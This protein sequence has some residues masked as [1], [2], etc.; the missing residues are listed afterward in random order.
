MTGLLNGAYG[1]LGII[2][3]VGII[4]LILFLVLRFFRTMF[5]LSFIGLLCSLFS[6]CVYEYTIAKFPVIAIAGMVFSIIGLSR[7]NL[8]CRIFSIV[9]IIISGYIICHSFGLF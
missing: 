7:K 4:I 8:F 6:Y 3:G 5:S 2:I 1:G 9:G